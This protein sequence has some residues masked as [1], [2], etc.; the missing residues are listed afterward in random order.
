VRNALPA[1]SDRS[2][3]HFRLRRILLVA[4]RSGE[5]PLTEPA[6]AAQAQWPEPVFMPHS[7]V[8][9]LTRLGLAVGEKK[10][11]RIAPGALLLYGGQREIVWRPDLVVK[12]Q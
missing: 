1:P 10:G 12:K 11:A 7:R 3:P 5:G 6:A 2:R 4:T 9:P 8:N